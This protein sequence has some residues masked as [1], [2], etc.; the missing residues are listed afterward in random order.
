MK[1]R[2]TRKNKMADPVV[3]V[4]AEDTWVKVATNATTGMVWALS[5]APNMYLC[6]YRDTGNPAPADDDDAV[7]FPSSS[8]DDTNPGLPI[9]ASA[10][11]DVYIKAKG[12]EGKVRVDL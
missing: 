8:P 6:T 3:V 11:I 12:A 2:K 7:I 5:V 10:G 9:S 4:C 1:T